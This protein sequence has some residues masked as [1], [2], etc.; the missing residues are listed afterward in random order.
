MILAM[1]GFTVEDM[2][3]KQLSASLPVGQVLFSLGIGSALIFAV[4]TLS[5][6]HALFAR[7][8][9]GRLPLWRMASEAIAAAAFVISLWLLDLSVVAAVFQVT[10][11]TITMGAALFLGEDVGWRRWTAISLGFLGVLLIIRPGFEGFDPNVIFVLISVLGVTVRDLVT[12]RMDTGVATSVIAFQGFAAVI[13]AGFLLLLMTGGQPVGLESIHWLMLLGTVGAGALGYY[14]L[15]QSTRVADA[16]VVTPF[17]YTRLLFAL[18]IGVI[19]F[20]ERPDL[21]TLSGAALI[22]ATGL[23]TFF[24][25]RR[26]AQKIVQPRAGI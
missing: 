10:P 16:A 17:R 26:M 21:L 24:R 13:P 20:Q 5:K 18:L 25:E 1:A 11:L 22:I 15:I 14:A 8:A 7:A 2:F 3:V 12:R 9:W 23:Y 19:V 4:M 6:G